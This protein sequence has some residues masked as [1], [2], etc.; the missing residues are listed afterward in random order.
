MPNQGLIELLK[1][2]GDALFT[3]CPTSE[4][5]VFFVADW[6][7]LDDQEVEANPEAS[8]CMS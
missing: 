5:L 1:Q 4:Q 3:N 7:L 2:Y 8:H 6:T